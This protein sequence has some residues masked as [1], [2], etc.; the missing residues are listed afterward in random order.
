LQLQ[1]SLLNAIAAPAGS[2]KPFAESQIK[3]SGIQGM[4]SDLGDQRLKIKSLLI[5]L[6]FLSIPKI[7][8]L[9][10]F[11]DFCKKLLT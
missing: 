5:S 7:P 10:F 2:L 6:K 3:S 8:E 11:R 4:K 1:A 9:F